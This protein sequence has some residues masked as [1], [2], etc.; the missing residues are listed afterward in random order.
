MNPARAAAPGE[1]RKGVPDSES[2]G[3]QEVERSSA[4]RE[5]MFWRRWAERASWVSGTR[6]GRS[7]SCRRPVSVGDD[8]SARAES[9]KAEDVSEAGEVRTRRASSGFED[10]KLGSLTSGI[11]GERSESAACRG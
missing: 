10:L 7:A 9:R 3:A 6:Q 8:G 11:S 5:R 1:G 4:G 2:A